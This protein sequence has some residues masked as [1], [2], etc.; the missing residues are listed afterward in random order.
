MIIGDVI[1][2]KRQKKNMTQAELAERLNITPQAVSRWEMGVSYPDI[3]MI[4]LL[5]KELGVSA[6]ELL[7]IVPSYQK[8]DEP[9][10]EESGEGP[11]PDL[12]QSQV[13]SIFDYVPGIVS[14]ENKKILVADDADFLRTILE[15]ILTHCG[16]TVLQAKDGQ[17]CLGILSEED[18]DVCLLD[19]HMPGMDGF[20]V[21]K[22]IRQ[23]KTG[24]KVVMISALAQEN[25]V[26][27][28][29]QL[30]AD[31][32]VVKPFSAECLVERIG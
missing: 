30:G 19:I 8:R 25:N 5:S 4:P 2:C 6:D 10:V 23:N 14:E 15:D 26:R 13:D 22:K 1:K 31:G 28:A 12:N 18:V 29:L 11:A 16:H 32:F 17:E 21:L 24:L 7:G 9:E 20:E 3:A 27:M